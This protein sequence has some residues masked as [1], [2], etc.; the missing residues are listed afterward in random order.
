[1]KAY[2]KILAILLS[3][4]IIL[5]AI[6]ACPWGVFAEVSD[7]PATADEVPE[8]FPDVPAT[9]DEA[10]TDQSKI[11]FEYTIKNGE[12]TVPAWKELPTS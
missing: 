12:V 1:M 7:S 9:A 4:T 11:R 8:E 5:S 10:T 3:L 6:F 2:G